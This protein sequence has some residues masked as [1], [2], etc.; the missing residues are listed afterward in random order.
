MAG[1][2]NIMI[3]KIGEKE[4]VKFLEKKGYKI[5]GT[6]VRTPFGELDIVARHKNATVFVEVKTRS[7]YSFG[8]PFLS[9]TWL[10]QRHLIKN[11][12]F[13]LKARRNLCSDWRI[14]V[15]SVK[16][17]EALKVES[18]ESIENAVEEI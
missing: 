12:L 18:I 2:G 10:K 1:R 3:G 4:A 9:V 13:Y 7:S 5:L 15:V 16:L 17:D 11:A 14:D 8:P 6:N